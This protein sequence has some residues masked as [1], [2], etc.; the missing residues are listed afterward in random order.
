MTP[1]L[2]GAGTASGSDAAAGLDAAARGRL[3]ALLAR[4]AVARLLAALD[5]DGEAVRIV[6]GAVRNALMDRGITD[7]DCTTTALPETVIARARPAS[8][9]SP[10]ASSTAPSP[11]SWRGIPSK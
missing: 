9:P 11:S 5:G 10:P 4:P 7:V 3:A 8:S 1:E 6:G 2:R